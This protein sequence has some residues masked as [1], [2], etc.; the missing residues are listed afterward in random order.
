MVS[1][2]ECP[3]ADMMKISENKN[4]PNKTIEGCTPD[5]FCRRVAFNIRA[6]SDCW[7]RVETVLV[8][9]QVIS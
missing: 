6:A 2:E 4:R 7:G 3:A 1:L 5:A 8:I 9:L